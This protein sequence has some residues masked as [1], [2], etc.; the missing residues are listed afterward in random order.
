LWKF[1]DP[2]KYDIFIQDE[3]FKEPEAYSPANVPSWPSTSVLSTTGSNTLRAH[4]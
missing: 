2:G 4:L 1:I 3:D